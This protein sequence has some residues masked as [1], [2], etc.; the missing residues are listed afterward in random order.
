MTVYIILE[1]FGYEGFEEPVIVFDSK[2]KAN[3]YVVEHIKNLYSPV[4][5][6]REVV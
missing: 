2:E 3:A 1:D 6:E 4:I 5:V